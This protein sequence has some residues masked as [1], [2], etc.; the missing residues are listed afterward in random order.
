MLNKTRKEIDGRESTK[1]VVFLL[2]VKKYVIHSVSM[3]EDEKYE[4]VW[5][6]HWNTEAVFTT[7][8]MAEDYVQKRSYDYGVEGDGYRIHGVS[9]EHDTWLGSLL[10][11]LKNTDLTMKQAKEL[12]LNALGERKSKK[13]EERMQKG[14]N[15]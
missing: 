7:R 10:Q 1:D 9:C 12:F 13:E 3:C 6:W 15:K 4:A 14:R 5:D 8:E 2:Q 11:E